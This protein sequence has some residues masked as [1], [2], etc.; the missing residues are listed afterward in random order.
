MKNLQDF[1]RIPLAVL[2]TPIQ[3]LENISRRA[4]L[5]SRVI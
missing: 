4:S 3:K 5:R 2:P 1:P